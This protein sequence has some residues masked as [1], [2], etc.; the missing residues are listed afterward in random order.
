M[1]DVTSWLTVSIQKMAAPVTKKPSIS[2]ECVFNLP[3]CG[4]LVVYETLACLLLLLI[5]TQLCV[6]Y[7]CMFVC[8]YVCMYVCGGQRH[9]KC[10]PQLHS[11][12]FFLLLFFY[13][14]MSWS[15]RKEWYKNE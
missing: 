12:L 4:V 10:L 7:V 13:Y 5:L 2:E 1:T 15:K 14:F 8:M 9:I 3:T 11:T 6:L